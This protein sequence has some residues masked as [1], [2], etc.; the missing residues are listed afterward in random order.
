MSGV[1]GEFVFT[2]GT[3]AF[4]S[5]T[6]VRHSKEGVDSNIKGIENATITGKYSIDSEV[7]ANSSDCRLTVDPNGN[8]LCFQ[9]ASADESVTLRN[10]LSNT[11]GKGY[12]EIYSKITVDF[13]EESLNDEFP[14][15]DSTERYGVNVEA[16]S[17]LA[18]DDRTLA[19]TSMSERYPDDDHFYYIE[20]IP[21]ATLRYSSLKDDSELYDNIGLNSK[22][23]STLGVNGRSANEANRT[24]M[25]V[26]TEAIYNVQALSDAERAS[27]LKLT[28]SLSKKETDP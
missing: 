2:E 27:I 6:L 7:D 17:N 20:S 5:I 1:A 19:Y 9:T 10:A 21:S 22:N 4:F 25:P 8:Y 11:S 24:S 12:F 15:R 18:Y 3:S 13:A 14:E 23:Q 26:N 28:F 16:A